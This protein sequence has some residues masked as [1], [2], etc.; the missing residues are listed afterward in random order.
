MARLGA[1]SAPAGMM[2]PMGLIFRKR[3]RV[4]RTT[5]VNLSA[6]GASVSRRAGRVTVNSRGRVSVRILPGLSF[7]VGGKW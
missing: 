1:V 2:S 4:S 3:V 6:H 7:R 5:H